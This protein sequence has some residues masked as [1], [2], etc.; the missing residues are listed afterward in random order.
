M[1]P[2]RAWGSRCQLRLGSAKI[3]HFS[4]PSPRIRATIPPA[5][6]PFIHPFLPPSLLSLLSLGGAKVSPHG[7][8]GIMKCK[9]SHAIKVIRN[10]P[11]L[12]ATAC[13]RIHHGDVASKFPAALARQ[14]DFTV[15]A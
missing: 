14:I 15:S 8:P 13:C 10:F 3:P 12:C 9:Q 1:V 6:P 5:I 11:P 7:G 4:F 2:G